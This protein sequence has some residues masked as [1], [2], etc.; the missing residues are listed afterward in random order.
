MAGDNWNY[1]VMAK[2]RLRLPENNQKPGSG[3]L[4]ILLHS[5]QKES[6]LPIP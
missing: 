4:K 1:V 6:I 5:S 2:E 3:M